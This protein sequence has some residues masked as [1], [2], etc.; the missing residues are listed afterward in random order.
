M[1]YPNTNLPADGI[2]ND[3]MYKNGREVNETPGNTT[4]PVSPVAPQTGEV[5]A[6]LL[7][8]YYDFD[9]SYLRDEAEPQLQNLQAMMDN[10]PEFVVEIGSHTD[11]RGEAYYNEWLSRKRAERAVEYIIGKGITGDRIVARGFGETLLTNDCGNGVE[12]DE[13]MHQANRRTEIKILE[14]KENVE[15]QYQK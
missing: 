9:Q 12:C 7:H 3:R 5:V 10:N 1:D 6:Y 14:L 11:S 13:I 8:I 15:V 2:I 4:F